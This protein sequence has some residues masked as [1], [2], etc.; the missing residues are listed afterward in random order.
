MDTYCAVRRAI[1]TGTAAIRFYDLIQAVDAF[2]GAVFDGSIPWYVTT[3]K[4]D[5][6]A[7]GILE[8]VPGK[9]PQRLRFATGSPKPYEA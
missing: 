7:R 8:R 9:G 2:I 3:V 5:L 1:E 6:E 4:L